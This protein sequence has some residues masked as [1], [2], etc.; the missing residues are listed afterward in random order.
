MLCDECNR[1]FHIFCLVPPLLEIPKE[2]WFCDDCNRHSLEEK[3]DDDEE[4]SLR[5]KKYKEM[6]MSI[7]ESE[8][9]KRKEHLNE[10]DNSD[11]EDEGILKK[12][13]I[14]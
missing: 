7:V 10:E 9:K 2:A 6:K 4:E 11:L 14:L 8:T 3:F 12:N 1:G 13:L 5:I